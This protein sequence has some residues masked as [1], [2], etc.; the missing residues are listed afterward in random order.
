MGF[1]SFKHSVPNSYV[2]QHWNTVAENYLFHAFFFSLFATA[3]ISFMPHY[4]TF[5]LSQV[6]RSLDQVF[7]FCC[8]LEH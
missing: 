7:Q 5:V 3:F 4:D 2:L 1:P 8:S 6:F